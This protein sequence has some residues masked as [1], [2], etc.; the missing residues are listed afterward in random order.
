MPVVH[1]CFISLVSVLILPSLYRSILSNFLSNK[2]DHYFVFSAL[3]LLVG[4]QEGHPTCKKTEWW[5]AGVV[6]CL[7][8]VQICIW[9]S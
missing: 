7:G 1:F 9:P 2:D 3:T 6:I 5:G 8:E 4:P